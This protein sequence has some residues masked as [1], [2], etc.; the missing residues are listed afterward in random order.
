MLFRGLNVQLAM[1]DFDNAAQSLINLGLD[2]RDLALISGLSS[3]ASVEQQEIH[4]VA[5]LVVDQ[6]KE[7]AAL[8]RSSTTVGGLLN[9]LRDKGQPL[10]FN[11][12]IDNQINAAAIKYNY[13]DFSN[14]TGNPKI[15]DIST[16]RVSSWSSI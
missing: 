11:L 1:N 14:P 7:L 15:A 8:A 9:S 10:D 12:E 3:S 2:Q 5:G 4:T 6:K 13:L 16:S